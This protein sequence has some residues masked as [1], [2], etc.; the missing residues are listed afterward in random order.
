[1][2][3][4]QLRQILQQANEAGTIRWIYFE[5]GEPFLY[6]ATLIKGVEMAANDGFEVGVVTN[7]YWATSPEDAVN[8]LRPLAPWIKDLT[9]SSDLYHYDQKLSQN[10]QNA[11]QAVQALHI[12]VGMICIA[13]PENEAASVQGQL[14]EGES[15]VMYRGRAAVKLAERA[16]LH[17]WQ[18][19]RECPFE[20][21]RDPGRVHLD[22]LGNVHICQGIS[23]GNIYQTPLAEICAGYEPDEHP[24]TGVL[25]T[26]GPAELIRRF[27]LSPAQGYADACHLCYSARSMLRA[28]FPNYLLPDQMYGI[29]NQ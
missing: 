13:Q 16:T 18:T 5:G 27:Q 23:L 10:A 25:L 12:P 4:G 24:I 20:D 8:W 28:R 2:T 17:P 3:L 19:F 6:Y 26:G 1:M 21:L 9:I 22:P 15:A 29:Y 14:S 11:Q 7:G